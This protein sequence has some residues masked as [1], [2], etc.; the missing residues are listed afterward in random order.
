MPK[1]IKQYQSADI[2]YRSSGNIINKLPENLINSNIDPSL[3]AYS[4]IVPCDD[5]EL[6]NVYV[7]AHKKY[8]SGETTRHR[9]WLHDILDNEGIPYQVVI[10]GY[11]AERRK[12]AED[13]FINVEKKHRKK[14]KRLIKEY[15]DPSND[16]TE[17]SEDSEFANYIDGIPQIKC[18]SC[19]REIDFDYQKCPHCKINFNNS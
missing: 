2:I 5:T 9:M 8:M 1:N 19:N 14:V 11:W 7:V 4:T 10:K 3:W 18:P 6:V 15:N 13:Q 16:A 12:F 17:I